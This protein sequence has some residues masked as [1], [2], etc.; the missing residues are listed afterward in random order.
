MKIK[1]PFYVKKLFIPDVRKTEADE[2]CGAIF[3][4]PPT[5]Q[6]NSFP[7]SHIKILFFS[8][9]QAFK[10]FLNKYSNT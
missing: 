2:Q 5:T 4:V 9:N 3:H 8:L 6:Y 7:Y 10:Y 1:R